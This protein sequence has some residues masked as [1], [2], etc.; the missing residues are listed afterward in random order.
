MDMPRSAFLRTKQYVFNVYQTDLDQRLEPM[1]SLFEFRPCDR[2]DHSAMPR[3]KEDLQGPAGRHVARGAAARR[4]HDLRGA[5][6]ARVPVAARDEDV[7]RPR[8]EAD[9]ALGDRFGDTTQDIRHTV[10]VVR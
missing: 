9:A 7:R 3:S 10:R 1:F 2:V 5:A 6:R 8:V 4:A